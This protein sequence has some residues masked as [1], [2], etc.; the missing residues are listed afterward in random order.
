M[1]T[2]SHAM[3]LQAII[4]LYNNIRSG[5]HRT[6]FPADPHTLSGRI[7]FRRY[8]AVAGSGAIAGKQQQE[9]AAYEALAGRSLASCH[10]T[11]ATSTSF[12]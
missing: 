7:P 9:A 8:P 4:V 12:P 3:A 6:C 11:L 10:A 1:P 2:I 5:F